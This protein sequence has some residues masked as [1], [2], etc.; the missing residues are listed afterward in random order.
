MY[1]AFYGLREKP[2]TLSPDPRYLFLSD[3]HREV[4]GHLIYGIEENEGF[5][6]ISGEVGT[7]KT[8]LCRTLLDRL[9]RDAEVAFLFNPHLGPAD[10]LHEIHAEF[11]LPGKPDSLP[12]LTRNLYAFLL[13]KKRKGRRVLLIIDEAQTLPIETLEQVRLLSNLETSHEKLLQIVLLGQPELDEKLSIQEL[14]QLRQRIGVWWHLGPLTQ[15]ETHDYVLHRLRIAGADGNLFDEAALSLIHDLS[16]GVPRVIN[17]LCDRALLAGYA[18]GSR[19]LDRKLLRGVAQE[20]DPARQAL[21]GPRRPRARLALALG[22]AFFLLVGG[23]LLQPG[24]I[25]VLEGPILPEVPAAEDPTLV[26]A[27]AL[28]ARAT[29]A[30]VAAPPP[31]RGAPPVARAS[32]VSDRAAV[33]GTEILDA[34]LPTRSQATVIAAAGNAALDAW[35]LPRSDAALLGLADALTV[36]RKQGLQALSVESADLSMLEELDL[37]VLVE[38][39]AAQGAQRWVLLRAIMGNQVDLQGLLPEET[40]RV[41][42]LD[43]VARW[44]GNAFVPWRDFEALPQILEPWQ[45]GTAV[46]WLQT[47]LLELGFLSGVPGGVFE[48]RTLEAVRNFQRAEA[49]EP[50]GLVGPRT[51]IQLYRALPQYGNPILVEEPGGARQSS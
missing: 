30:G 12:E 49:L 8:T 44:T 35:N 25:A 9:G 6:A 50:D 45:Q 20:I 38:L 10:L 43:F 24:G 36:L 11:D 33:S 46:R 34:V 7:G 2:F 41:D 3:T 19:K 16:Q 42:V 17:L 4:L 51:K 27:L 21:P 48:A 26:V 13:E 47:S 28:P 37:P 23:T 32:N 29:H 5:I 15:P 40:V 1:T 31:A 39:R 18:A 22:S 14:R